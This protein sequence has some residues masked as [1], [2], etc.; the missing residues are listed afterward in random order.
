[1]PSQLRR[2][3]ARDIVCRKDIRVGLAALW[4]WLLL[5]AAAPATRADSFRLPLD[6]YPIDG[7]C[8]SWGEFNSKFARCGRPG[9]HV[10]DDACAPNGTPVMAVADGR[11]CFAARV[12]ECADNWG[13]LVVVEHTLPGE[14]QVCSIYGH[15]EPVHGIAAGSAVVRGQQIATI[16]NECVPHIH[17]GIY[18]G[19]FGGPDGSYPSWLLGYLPDG[20]TCTEH[21]AAW[22]GNFVDPVWFILDRLT[23]APRTWNRVQSPLR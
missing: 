4:G 5:C 11:V 17:F 23:V 12:G 7:P 6:N 20:T 16:Q 2:P 8:L 14:P 9:K 22:P 10:A 21:P 15:C 13:W 18:A 3:E 1:M 19:A